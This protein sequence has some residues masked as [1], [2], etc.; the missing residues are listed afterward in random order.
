MVQQVGGKFGTFNNRTDYQPGAIKRITTEFSRGSVP[1]SIVAMDRESAWA[2]WRR[3]YEIAVAVGIQKS[4][5]FPFRYTL[6][7][8][9]GTTPT[10]GNDPVII[11]V[12]QG[13]PT[14]NKES[15]IHWTGC[16]VSALLR[17]DNV[18]DSVGTSA[19]VVSFTEDS[20]Y[21]YVQLAGTWSSVNPLPPPLYIPGVGGGAALKPLIG[22]VVED[23]VL[24]AQGIPITAASRDPATDT[25]YGYIQA[26]LISIDQDTGILKIQKNGS[27]ESTI[28][29]RFVTPATRPPAIG[30]FLILGSRY[31]CTC[32][33]FNRR[34][35]ID[36]TK[37]KDNQL[38]RRFPYTRPAGLKFGRHELLTDSFG[39]I[40]NNADTLLDNNRNLALTFESIDNPGLF[41]D[42][43]GRYLRN[44]S[45]PG[46]SEGPATFADYTAKDNQIIT[47]SDYWSPLLDE[48][49]YCKHIYALRF[50]E[51]ILLPEPSDLPADM[52]EGIVNWEQRLTKE[53]TNIKTNTDYMNSLKGLSYM[54]MPPKNLQSPQLLPML[55]KLLNIPSSFIRLENFSLQQK[56]GSFT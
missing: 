53:V 9:E 13:F 27:F 48:M 46:A 24:T 12:L 21:W 47:F 52:D 7:L 49:R 23:R 51:G 54:D 56:D 28:D 4:Y 5:N 11:G 42:F 37:R 34:S 14:S 26:L 25:R 31:S 35:Y 20:D 3:G 33:D 39:N 8:P 22:E 16:R 43:G 38:N 18:F 45:S 55:Q 32:Q 17:F 6:P 2:R 15:G 36:F 19:S 40:N 30:R 1:N 10:P 50:Q 44:T 29:G 41:R